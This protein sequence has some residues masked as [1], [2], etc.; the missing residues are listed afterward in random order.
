MAGGRGGARPNSPLPRALIESAETLAVRRLDTNAN[1]A[2]TTFRNINPVAHRLAINNG[3]QCGYC[4]VGFVMNMSELITT[5]P[6]ATKQE[7]E[8]AFDGNLCRCTGYRPILSSMKTFASDWNKK[9]QERLMLCIDD[10]SVVIPDD[11]KVSLPVPSDS[12]F[13]GNNLVYEADLKWKAPKTL[14]EWTDI[15]TQVISLSINFRHIN[16]GTSFG[17]YKNEFKDVKMFIDISRIAEMTKV[18]TEDDSEVVIPAV[19]TYDQAIE[20]INS[21]KVD[22]VDYAAKPLQSIE[23]M[24]KR[25]AGRIVRNAATLAGN[26]MMYVLHVPDKFGYNWPQTGDP[27]PSDLV[28]ALINLGAEVGV[29]IYNPDSGYDYEFTSIE[30]LGQ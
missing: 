23:Y 7:I 16:G 2:A 1:A 15:M 6:D 5:H 25:T 12:Q 30:T 19:Y 14:G 18:P 20:Y 22:G 4:S 9:D 3:S 28:T 13:S 8:D 24:L 26:I 11:A 29:H 27:F 10:A 17:I 21:R